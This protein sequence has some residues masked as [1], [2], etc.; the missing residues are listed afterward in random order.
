MKLIIW[1]LMS[2]ILIGAA[3]ASLESAEIDGNTLTI[4]ST[5]GTL[6]VLN[7][8]VII[9]THQI[10]N[11]QLTMD[12]GSLEF[13]VLKFYYPEIVI[14]APLFDAIKEGHKTIITPKTNADTVMLSWV[15]K[16]YGITATSQTLRYY[17][18]T[19]QVDENDKTDNDCGTSYDYV[20][21]IDDD[22]ELRAIFVLGYLQDEIGNGKYVQE[23]KFNVYL[24]E[25]KDSGL[26]DFL[27][28]YTEDDSECD[29]CM[30]WY[31][32][33]SDCNIDRDYHQFKN[34]QRTDDDVWKSYDVTTWVKSAYDRDKYVAISAEGDSSGGNIKQ[35][36]AGEGSSNYPP[37]IDI[38]YII[39][40]C[41]SGA[42][43]SNGEFVSSSTICNSNL[44]TQYGCPWGNDNDDDVGTRNK[45]QYCSGNN[46]D[47]IGTISYVS[48]SVSDY[49]NNDE[50]CLDNTCQA[51]SSQDSSQCFGDDIYWYDS[52]NRKE[53]VKEDCG[54]DSCSDYM[55]YC[56]DDDSYKSRSCYTK[57]CSA[58]SC[59]SESNV[60]SELVEDCGED[61]CDD[62]RYYCNGDD[63]YKKRTCYEKGCS[64]DCYSI[65]SE[66]NDLVESCQLGCEIGQCISYPKNVE[67]WIANDLAW[68]HDGYFDETEI[69][70]LTDEVEKFMDIYCQSDICQVPI[71]V[72]FESESIF[73]IL[74]LEIEYTLGQCLE[75]SD[76]NDDFSCTTEYC[77]AYVCHYELDNSTCNDGLFCNGQET[78]SLDGCQAGNELICND[79]SN[80][81]CIGSILF[82]NFLNYSCSEETENCVLSQTINESECSFDCG[83]ECTLDSDCDDG[84]NFTKNTCNNCFCEMEFVG[85]CLDN[86]DCNDNVSCTVESCNQNSFICEHS[87]ENSLCDD[88]LYCNGQETCLLDGCQA[89]EDIICDG[90]INESCGLNSLLISTYDSVCNENFDDCIY[91]LQNTELE[92]SLDCDSECELNSDCDDGDNFTL[93][94]CNNCSCENNFLGECSNDLDCD[95]GIDCTY[96]TCNQNNH[97]CEFE[98]RDR[99]CE[100]GLYC[101]GDETCSLSG[102]VAGDN[103]DCSGNNSVGSSECNGLYIDL[104]P[105]LI[106]ICEEEIGS[107]TLL[108]EPLSYCSKT[109]G[110]ECESDNDCDDGNSISDDNCA[111]CKCENIFDVKF[112]KGWNLVSFPNYEEESVYELK[113]SCIGVIGTI[114]YWDANSY[115]RA[116]TFEPEFGYWIYSKEPCNYSINLN[117]NFTIPFS[118]GDGWNLVGSQSTN[119][120]IRELVGH[121][122]VNPAWYYKNDSYYQTNSI[123]PGLGSWVYYAS[124]TKDYSMTSA[125]PSR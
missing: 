47:C 111:D 109:C 46:A 110:A 79:E 76:C 101:N 100:D 107:C 30:D 27:I 80:E 21:D 41:T 43:C 53:D 61:S 31:D 25:E 94:V 50:H 40:D 57:G 77:E 3:F 62:Y 32:A 52:C 113:Q 116:S 20:E 89:G 56:S 99:Y 13:P 24:D 65:E 91:Y 19:M 34:E 81:H 106:S 67:L 12:L 37:Y 68:S 8:N 29:T 98:L 18:D 73:E 71:D 17:L 112:D 121:N 7:G 97:Q 36:L 16:S 28:S 93:D 48:W 87:V 51:C 23:A 124:N 5:Q 119:I 85:E 42:C 118:L 6:E 39:P 1:F 15:S 117:Y 84:Q 78:C 115:K 14:T 83:A 9:S 102:C 122:R 72:N 69:V 108:G 105:P 70:E 58:N 86:S 103:V 96:E 90:K 104:Y 45:V 59:T 10:S 75:D 125:P 35:K 26:F 38:K 33:F 63:V 74:E 55:Y 49:C 95:D 82:S 22:E 44:E 92:C 66:D 4:K 60:E 120:S 88:G 114:W 54:D 123:I 11:S 64:G 2:I